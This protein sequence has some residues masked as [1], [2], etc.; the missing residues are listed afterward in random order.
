MACRVSCARQ[1]SSISRIYFASTPLL[2][3]T[4]SSS[5]YVLWCLLIISQATYMYV[6]LQQQCL[7][8]DDTKVIASNE[9]SGEGRSGL[10]RCWITW[11][12]PELAPDLA[13]IKDPARDTLLCRWE[14][15][16]IILTS[17]HSIFPSIKLRGYFIDHTGRFVG[18]ATSHVMVI[19]FNQVMGSLP[20]IYFL[21]FPNNCKKMTSVHKFY[22]MIQIDPVNKTIDTTYFRA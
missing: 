13:I 17:F 19:R 16:G 2:S 21:Q 15:G 10:H 12:V 20:P 1:I 22:F 11:S 8:V 6:F 14:W 5:L 18:V 7:C 4:L 9:L 3:R